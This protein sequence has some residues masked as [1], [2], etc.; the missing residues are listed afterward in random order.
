[1]IEPPIRMYGPE[2]EFGDVDGAKH[3]RDE[4]ELA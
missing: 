4:K 1:L 2:G 3:R